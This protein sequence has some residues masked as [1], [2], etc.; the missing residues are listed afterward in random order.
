V[1]RDRERGGLRKSDI[2]SGGGGANGGN[3]D[4]NSKVC[5]SAYV[6]GCLGAERVG[7]LAVLARTMHEYEHVEIVNAETGEQR[8]SRRKRPKLLWVFGPYW[9]INVC[10]TYPL[11][12][13][14]S[15]LTFFRSIADDFFSH[16]GGVSGS[17]YP[18]STPPA[19]PR[20][21][22]LDVE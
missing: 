20:F 7:N 6:C 3:F 13:G 1:T 11:I 21:R 5:C 17:R 14:I 8:R 18:I 4:Q 16:H 22:G 9:Y 15:L 12:I 19:T 10:L 2:V